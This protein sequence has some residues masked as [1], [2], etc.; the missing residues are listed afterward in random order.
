MFILVLILYVFLLSAPSDFPAGSVF[1]LSR[2]E[3]TGSAADDLSGMHAIRSTFLFKGFVWLFSFG[4]MRIIEGYYALDGRQDVVQVAWRMTHADFA[5]TRVKVTIPE[6]R[7]DNEIGDIMENTLPDF[8]ENAFL[9]FVAANDLQG[10][11]F[12]DT[13]FLIP[14]ESAADITKTMQD[15]FSAQVAPL[16]PEIEKSG[17]SEADIITFASILE[18]EGNSTTSMAIISG[19][20]WKRLSINMALQVDSDPWT[21]THRGLPVSPIANPGLAAIEAAL[22]PIKTQ[23]LYFL[24][25]KNGG[26]HYAETLD[27]QTANK[28]K[29]LK[30]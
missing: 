20:L 8:D 19:I 25:D 22:H 16:A 9:S 3:T 26:M 11:L 27:E 4:Q 17:H 24:T 23:Y 5:T 15:N 13:Y 14:G 18:R 6:G 1:H 12:P 21:Y 28:L 30:G 29:Y 7:N 2:G 10:Y